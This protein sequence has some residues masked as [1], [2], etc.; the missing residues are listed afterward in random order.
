L[1]FA[2]AFAAAPALADDMFT[3]GGIHVDAS[4]ASASTAQLAAIAQGRPKAWDIL[5]RRLVHQQDWGKEPKLDDAS[6]QRIIRSFLVKNERRSTTRYV[7]DVTYEFSPE[8]VQRVLGGVNI[9]FAQS[10]PK[11]ILLVPFAPGYS[12]NSSW[13]FAF[14][15]PRFTSTAV[16][17]ALPAGDAFEG[18]GFDT[19]NWNDLSGA[20]ARVHATEA[21][22][23]QATANGKTLTLT[24][25]RLGAGELPTKTSIDVPMLP[26]GAASTYSN[27]ADA[28]VKQIEEIWKQHSAADVSGTGHLTAD[29]RI[30]SLT[31][32]T[33]LQ[34]QM[35]AVP[36][37]SG[38]AVQA[39]D[40]GEV[41][42]TLAYLGTTDQLKDALA[43]QG[44]SLVRNGS[45][46]SLSGTEKP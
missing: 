8:G 29:V 36:N 37:V 10:Q 46:W 22:L 16:P 35:A 41:R 17:F 19:A 20:A 21:V 14:T 42:I 5:Y 39:M 40:I 4:A 34:N 3:V 12:R 27:A 15:S 33:S 30:A 32:W 6:L 26:G 43:A 1:A 44:I 9:A 31:Q 45:E 25:R 7:G 38:I 11:R 28:A 18:V 13:T 23:V 24:F 2:L